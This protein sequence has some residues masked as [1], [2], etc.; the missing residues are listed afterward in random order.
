MNVIENKRHKLLLIDC[1]LWIAPGKKFGYVKFASRQSAQQAM[2]V[3][4]GQTI[5][6]NRLKVLPAEP[7]RRKTDDSSKREHSTGDSSMRDD[8]DISAPRGKHSRYDWNGMSLSK[9][10]SLAL[11]FISDV[12]VEK[13]CFQI[14]FGWMCPLI[15]ACWLMDKSNVWNDNNHI[16]RKKKINSELLWR[17]LRTLLR[18]DIW[19][20]IACY[21]Q[22][23]MHC[24]VR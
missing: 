7:M 2:D 11:P 4:H 14:Y 19:I 8:D 21:W 20:K 10:T 1:L 5:C 15:S 24:V 18:H 13:F 9:L 23:C 16:V 3:L 6:G 12:P 17:T 22:V